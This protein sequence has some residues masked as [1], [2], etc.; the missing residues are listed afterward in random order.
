MVFSSSGN[1]L[2][3]KWARHEKRGGKA[4]V[5]PVG[6]VGFGLNVLSK[7]DNGNNDWLG[8]KNKSGEYAI[9]YIGINNSYNDK[10]QMIED[11][12]SLSQDMEAINNKMYIQ[13]DNLRY[14][15]DKKVFG[16]TNIYA[17]LRIKPK[18]IYSK[19]L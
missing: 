18:T 5:P 9:G 15:N 6:W 19:G 17:K 3:G 1:N 2:L 8:C 4:Y 12:S 11:I 10:D 14:R 13:D 7:Y 16:V